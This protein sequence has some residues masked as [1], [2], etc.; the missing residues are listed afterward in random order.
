V[1]QV[2][3]IKRCLEEGLYTRTAQSIKKQATLQLYP[4]H[5]TQ[6]QMAEPVKLSLELIRNIEA[7]L[8]EHF[9]GVYDDSTCEA[10]VQK[11]NNGSSMKAP[12]EDSK[13]LTTQFSSLLATLHLAAMQTQ[14]SQESMPATYTR[15]NQPPQPPTV[16]INNVI[17]TQSTQSTQANQSTHSTE[18]RAPAQAKFANGREKAENDAREIKDKEDDERKS[19]A[20][21]ALTVQGA[22]LGAGMIGL[23]SFVVLSDEYAYR[24][25]MSPLN[26]HL[27]DLDRQGPL[28]LLGAAYVQ[29]LTSLYED[30]KRRFDART[31]GVFAGKVGMGTSLSVLA[32]SLYFA[33]PVLPIAAVVGVGTS[34]AYAAWKYLDNS[35]RQRAFQ[36]EKESFFNLLKNLHAARTHLEQ[37]L[38]IS[39]APSAPDFPADHLPQNQPPP[40]YEACVQAGLIVQS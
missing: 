5:R 40:P 20:S 31:F 22:A 33:L 1:I 30:W 35:K 24:T 37:H 13:L 12:A 19:Q 4:P 3:E 10:S 34:G 28:Q 26:T 18:A 32:G 17:S 6:T 25:W 16:I 29:N 11:T 27:R 2:H 23:A 7:E 39:L 15:F 21:R 14:E 8:T 38:Q 36:Q 9:Q